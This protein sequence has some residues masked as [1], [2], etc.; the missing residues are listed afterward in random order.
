MVEW[1]LPPPPF[2]AQQESDPDIPFDTV[3]WIPILEAWKA[4]VTQ[5][6]WKEGWS[7][8]R[9]LETWKRDFDEG[10]NEPAELGGDWARVTDFAAKFQAGEDLDPPT[11][12]DYV[13]DHGE[14][15]RNWLDGRHRVVGAYL[16][17]VQRVPLGVI[18]IPLSKS[19]SGIV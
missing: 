7:L 6:G 8:E 18:R 16:A 19:K 5:P 2:Y 17:K 9:T 10:E 1:I 14:V 12:V 3:K 11:I 15:V 13:N 4:L